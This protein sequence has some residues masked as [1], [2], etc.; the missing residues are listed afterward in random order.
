MRFHFSR[1]LD[2]KRPCH[3]HFQRARSIAAQRPKPR[4]RAIVGPLP[5]RRRLRKV[6]LGGPPKQSRTQRSKRLI[7]GGIESTE[8]TRLMCPL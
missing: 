7:H 3:T 6:P 1:G 2:D 8:L 5:F 4:F